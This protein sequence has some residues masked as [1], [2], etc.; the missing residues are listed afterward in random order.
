MDGRTLCPSFSSGLLVVMACGSLLGCVY[1]VCSYLSIPALRQHPAGIMFGMS[2]YGLVYYILYLLDMLSH[3][4][5]C[6][7][8]SL[9]VDFFFTGHETYVIIFGLDLLLAL[10]N[11]F[12]VSKNQITWYH[13]GVAMTGYLLFIVF[14]V[15]LCSCFCVEPCLP[16]CLV[17]NQARRSTVAVGFVK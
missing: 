8:V 1:V 3:L 16:S 15:Y 9:Y 6:S 12:S 7:T 2:L 4:I 11:P 14:Q 13:L 5:N 10:S 17:S